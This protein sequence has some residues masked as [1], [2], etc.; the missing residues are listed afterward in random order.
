MLVHVEAETFMHISSLAA[1]LVILLVGQASYATT[2]IYLSF[3]EM[4][5]HAELIVE[6][7]VT[8]LRVFRKGSPA[9]KSG[10][11]PNTMAPA[12]DPQSAG[13]ASPAA[14]PIASPR[15][16]GVEGGMMIF[17]E[18]TLKVSDAI[19]GSVGKNLRFTMA[20][21]TSH[22]R[23]VT[24]AAMPSFEVGERYILFLQSNYRTNAAPIMGV[25][26]G[27]FHVAT[28]KAGG[29][30]M[31]LNSASDMVLGV[32]ENRVMVRRNPDRGGAGQRKMAAPPV[33]GP[34][35]PRP[36]TSS[37]AAQRYWTSTEP[38]MTPAGFAEIIRQTRGNSR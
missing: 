31:V 6:G 13:S 8:K 12:A 19:V 30:E 25:N 4:T 21:G 38:A 1:A 35:V 18:V 24:V 23:T 5:D 27:Y 32:E 28:P 16:A 36:V 33:P 2:P 29:P 34:N 37:A 9:R 3:A 26:Q 11:A 20:G 7:T 10:S 14:A 22:G 17:T 15:A